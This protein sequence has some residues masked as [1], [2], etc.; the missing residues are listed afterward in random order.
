MVLA[1]LTEGE[2]TGGA[3][4]DEDELE[5]AP[6]LVMVEVATTR[7]TVWVTVMVDVDELDSWATT[8]EA[9]DSARARAV[10][11]VVARMMT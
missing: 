10:K 4:V 7:D 6:A 9:G 1:A 3:V 8:S 2:L 5:E 11:T